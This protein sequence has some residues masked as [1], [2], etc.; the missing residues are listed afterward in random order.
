M[1]LTPNLL[2]LNL[3][4]FQVSPFASG[5]DPNGF[6]FTNSEK[7]R[8]FFVHVIYVCRRKMRDVENYSYQ[9]GIRGHLARTARFRH[10]LPTLSYD[11]MQSRRS[12]L[13]SSRINAFIS[14][15][16]KWC[17]FGGDRGWAI[18][19]KTVSNQLMTII[20]PRTHD[21]LFSKGVAPVNIN[22]TEFMYR[23][24]SS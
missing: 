4:E 18:I 1:V 21:Y 20:F 3:S 24:C 8:F 10:V 2:L 22:T 5:R 13:L 15:L 23:R 19:P 14:V 6:L 9:T 12:I 11:E 16:L 7:K 17:F